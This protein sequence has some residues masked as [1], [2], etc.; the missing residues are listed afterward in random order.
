M[1]GV[2]RQWQVVVAAKF[3]ERNRPRLLRPEFALSP[4]VCCV[5]G[6]Q[7]G[8]IAHLVLATLIVDIQHDH[9]GLSDVLIAQAVLVSCARH[10]SS[11]CSR[12]GS[13]TGA[14]RLEVHLSQLVVGKVQGNVQGR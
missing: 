5:D 12:S 11:F 8:A 1:A 7:N 10:V 9:V 6:C 2:G 13:F 3:F 14:L 4:R